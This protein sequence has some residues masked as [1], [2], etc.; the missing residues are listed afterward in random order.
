MDKCPKCKKEMIDISG[1]MTN[2]DSQCC[3]TKNCEYFG[4]QRYMEE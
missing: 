1:M 3:N 2:G 4:I